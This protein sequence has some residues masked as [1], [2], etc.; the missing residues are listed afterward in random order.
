[1]SLK[2][3]PKKMNKK[4]KSKKN[5][6][7]TAVKDLKNKIL[8]TLSSEPGKQLNYKQ[9]SARLHITDREQRKVLKDCLDALV[10][11]KVIESPTEGKYVFRPKSQ[12]V[13]GVLEIT[14]AGHGFVIADPLPDGTRMPDI[15]I[16]KEALNRALPGDRVQVA[17]YAFKR[18]DLPHGEIIGIL[19]RERTEFV[20]TFMAARKK[21]GFVV[22]DNKR[23]YTDFYIGEENKNG[24]A[25]GD[26]VVVQLTDWPEQATS[27]FGKIIKVL[28]RPGE[29]ETEIHSILAEYDLPYEFPADVEEEAEKIPD[30]LDPKEIS[31]RRDFRGVVTFT[32][33]PEDAKDFDDALSVRPLE[34]GNLEVGVH[35]ADVT[36][37]VRPGSK[38]D[39][40]AYQR[41]TS[42]YLVDRVVPMLPEK[43]SNYLCSL[44]PKEDK[45]CFSAVFEIDA[46]AHVH[47]VWF[48]RTIIH[49]QR[50][51]T[52][53]EA[54]GILKTGK[55]DFARELKILNSIAKKLRTQRFKAGSIGFDKSEVKFILDEKN[56]PTGVYQKTIGDSN[57]LI[58][59][60]MLLANKYVAMAVGRNADGKPSGKIMVYRVHDDPDP[61]K[62]IELQGFVSRFGYKLHI[63]SLKQIT[64]SINAMLNAVKGKPEQN[65]IETLAIRS[66]AK[67]IY[68]TKNRGHY[69]LGFEYYTHFTSPIRRYPDVMVHRILQWHLEG[70]EAKNKNLWE[71]KCKHS[72]QREK[73]ATDAERASVKY[74]M[75]KFL[76]DKIGKTFEGVISGVTEYGIYVELVDNK[77]EG[78]IRISDF[79]DDYYIF[80][81]D[82]YQLIGSRKG[83]IYQL[84]EKLKVRVKKVDLQKK[85]ID[86][87]VVE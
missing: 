51:F 57:H 46:K 67:A 18:R 7:I 5:T 21:Y 43:L 86:F 62:L 23:I 82:N 56:N 4:T 78:M 69:G 37:Y 35:I 29:H 70:K 64:N 25:D 31:K 76:M 12:T 28:G 61:D 40:E 39:E 44:R 72:S 68:S 33:D 48:G 80:D 20:G 45:F 30:K 74:M 14:N 81:E 71:E 53:E 60:F 8:K 87:S 26:K 32:I 41:G 19:E 73:L 58:E 42:V 49:S 47:S 9:V 50:R 75:S 59:E 38:I 17:L 79:K 65:L 34:N 10:R 1:M 85:Q 3:K 66:M 13:L 63:S 27:P 24:A 54:E 77:C 22:P 11:D 15:F 84:G 16:D 6:Q 55:G 36:Y 2:F 83:K 52:Y